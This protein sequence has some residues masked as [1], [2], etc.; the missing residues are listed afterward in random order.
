MSI[1]YKFIAVIIMALVTYIIRVVPLVIFQGEI[2]SRFLKS[3]LSYVPYAVL[4]AM[5]FPSILYS[6]KYM[7]SA[8]AG[9]IIA[10]LVAYFNKSLLK[11]AISGIA[12]VYIV[13]LLF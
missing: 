11:V 12:T 3:F 13:E 10:L 1:S 4:G 9:L 2:K 7:Y 8:I 5:T 6:T